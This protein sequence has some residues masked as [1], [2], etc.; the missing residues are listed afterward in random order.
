[1]SLSNDTYTTKTIANQVLETEHFR[2]GSSGTAAVHWKVSTGSHMALS[3]A[4]LT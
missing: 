2:T 3:N 1:M 4:H